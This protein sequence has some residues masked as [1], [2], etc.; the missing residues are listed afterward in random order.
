MHGPYR[1]RVLPRLLS[2]DRK[3]RKRQ[4]E[5]ER[6]NEERAENVMIWRKKRKEED[7]CLST[8]RPDD[9][10]SRNLWNVSKLLPDHT[11]LQPRRQPSLNTRTWEPKILQKKGGTE[12]SKKN[13]VMKTLLPWMLYHLSWIPSSW[14][15]INQDRKQSYIH[16]YSVETEVHSLQ[17]FVRWR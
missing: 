15:I 7:G 1:D 11:A 9:G 3:T 5:I 6:T 8:H 13:K 4:R 10:G 12:E 14:S 17:R 2:K 16:F